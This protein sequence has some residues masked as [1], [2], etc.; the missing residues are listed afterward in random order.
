MT[1]EVVKE[2]KRLQDVVALEELKRHYDKSEYIRVLDDLN[3]EPTEAYTRLQGILNEEYTGDMEAKLSVL[4]TITIT[5][6]CENHLAGANV[7]RVVSTIQPSVEL[8]Y[9]YVM[10]R[11]IG[12]KVTQS[13]LE[14]YGM[15][16]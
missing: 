12:K 14:R 16:L 4:G 8:P 7:R 10:G 6:K 13:I 5:E 3:Y 15:T 11:K 9:A 2:I 1:A